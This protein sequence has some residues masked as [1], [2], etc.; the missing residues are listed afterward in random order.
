MENQFSAGAKDVSRYG[1]D[2]GWRTIFRDRR[3]E[4][5]SLALYAVRHWGGMTWLDTKSGQWQRS[6]CPPIPD[7]SA[8][9]C[10]E[11]ALISKFGALFTYGNS[12]SAIPNLEG[13]QEI[14]PLEISLRQLESRPVTAD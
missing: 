6:G 5:E 3:N 9:H 7:S 11:K 8:W 13:G 4:R 10:V 1:V 2:G 14:G 12:A